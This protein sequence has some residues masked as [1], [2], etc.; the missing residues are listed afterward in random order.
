M[1]TPRNKCGLP[2]PMLRVPPPSRWAR[3]TASARE[4]IGSLSCMLA[5]L[6]FP[7]STWQIITAAELYG[8]GYP[9]VGALRRLRRARYRTV[10]EIAN[11]L[12]ATP[13]DTGLDNTLQV[14]S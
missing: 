6:H 5:D 14:H 7:A 1:I 12:L 8:A 13:P 10:L 2:M 11:D 4:L 3:D 9:T